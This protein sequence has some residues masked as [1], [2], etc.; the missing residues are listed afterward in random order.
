MDKKKA[1]EHEKAV[2]MDTFKKRLL[3]L[4]RELKTKTEE[5]NE[6]FELKN[7]LEKEKKTL[8]IEREKMKERIKKLKAKKGKFDV[9]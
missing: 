3:D 4:D 7:Q 5:A 6:N 8:V 2:A 9:A 1:I